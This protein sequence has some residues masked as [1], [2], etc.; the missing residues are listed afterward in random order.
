MECASRKRGPGGLKSG[1]TLREKRRTEVGR[2]RDF[3]KNHTKNCQCL[4]FYFCPLGIFSSFPLFKIILLGL[5]SDLV[6]G[7]GD[8][9]STEIGSK[10]Q[11]FI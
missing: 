9:L 2:H 1:E 11:I 7:V 4:T 5:S 6:L 3:L 10:I 8:A